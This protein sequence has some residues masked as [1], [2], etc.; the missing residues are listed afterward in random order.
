MHAFSGDVID[1]DPTGLLDIYVM[2]K[3]M[4]V[5]RRCFVWA[6]VLPLVVTAFVGALSSGSCCCRWC[7][8]LAA[9]RFVIAVVF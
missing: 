9:A 7:A 6:C 1:Y 5:G 8:R 2:L 3:F 4:L